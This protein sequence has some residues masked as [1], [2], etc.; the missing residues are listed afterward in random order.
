MTA[1]AAAPVLEVSGLSVV[2]A[3]GVRAVGGAG[4]GVTAGETLA[5]AGESGAG[6]SATALALV[7]LLPASAR[8]QGSVRLRG[9]ELLGLPERELAAVRGRGIA[10]VFQDHAFTPVH[11]IGAQIAEAVRAHR[12][13]SRRAAIA[14]AAESLRLA[15]VQDAAAVARAYPHQLSGGQRRR[16]MIAVAMAADPSVIVAD[17]PTAGLD[18]PARAQVL[19]ALRAVQRRTGAALILITHDL[20]LAAER[21]DRITVMHAGRTVE[22]GPAATASTDPSM[23]RTAALLRSVPRLSRADAVLPGPRAPGGRADTPVVLVV[24]G[25]VKDHPAPGG[26]RVVDGVGFDVRAGEVLGLVGE[27]GCGKTTTLKEIAALRT[28]VVFGHDVASLSARR[29]RELRRDLQL[30]FQDS[31]AALD[32]RMTAGAILAEPLR[33]HGRPRPEIAARVPELLRLVGLDP[34]HA[35]RRPGELSGGQ[36]QRVGIARALALEPRL[37]L[38]DEPFS[39]LDVSTQASVIALLHDLKA[40][41]GLAYLIAA[42]DLAALRLLADRV[43]VMRHGRILEIGDAE[44]VYG[45]PAHPYT[46]TL[47]DAVPPP[48]RDGGRRL[49]LQKLWTRIDLVSHGTTHQVAW[50]ARDPPGGCRYRTRCPV[51][52]ALPAH[53]RRRCVM[54]EPGLRRLAPDHT[55]ACHF[56]GQ[57]EPR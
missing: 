35:G 31:A 50:E 44:A 3:G 32:P 15:G 1:G 11:R 24:D 25:L 28:G 48:A 36:R 41:L 10:I 45:R 54:Q 19:D 27:S 52:S 22:S 23:P 51:F 38:L 14:R 46:R 20:G 2:F 30:V 47:L 53:D 57:G 8:V 6:K 34:A 12:R 5:V 9:R 42:H 17:E 4:F 18:P 55:A 43:A 26:L 37:L 7:G 39:A 16:A 13:V 49:E 56:P 33:A 29:R 40:R 21:A